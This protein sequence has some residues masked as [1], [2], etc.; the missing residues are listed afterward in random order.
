MI[1]GVPQLPRGV[2]GDLTGEDLRDLQAGG[3]Y[4][5]RNGGNPDHFSYL[6]YWSDPAWQP[7]IVVNAEGSWQ[8]AKKAGDGVAA[9]M[10]SAL[11]EDELRNQNPTEYAKYVGD[12]LDCVL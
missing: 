10:R 7:D 12:V 8:R 6:P 11:L 5:K 1:A 9:G 4:T 3:G 2:R